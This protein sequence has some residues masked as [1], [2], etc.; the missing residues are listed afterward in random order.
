MIVQSM[1]NSFKVELLTAIHDFSTSGDVFKIALFTAAAD[2]S[3]NTT[4]YSSTNEI[5]GTNYVAGGLSLTSIAPILFGNVG[6][7]DFNDITWNNLTVSGV[8]GALIYNSSKS[9]RAVC[10]LD[11]GSD[12]SAFAA[13][14]TIIFPDADASSAII[15]VQ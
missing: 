7:V 12:R 3:A 9:N 11:F 15:R 4:A 5:I 6:V 14:F 2:L 8:R 13:P 10:V 1:C